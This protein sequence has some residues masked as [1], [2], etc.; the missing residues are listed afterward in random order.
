MKRLPR[1]DALARIAEICSENANALMQAL[2]YCSG[3]GIG[4]F[5]I[6]SQILPLKT[7]PE[8]GYS[9]GD[10]PSGGR[11]VEAFRECSRF[12]RAAMPTAMV[13]LKPE[14]TYLMTGLM[15]ATSC[16]RAA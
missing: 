11:I 1:R 5:R 7:H 8:V 4:C 12:A 2:E 13:R 6:N 14:P 3:H 16:R 9:I 15:I 10:L